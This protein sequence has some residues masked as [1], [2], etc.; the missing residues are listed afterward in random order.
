MMLALPQIIR[1]NSCR[2]PC[3]LY[4]VRTDILDLV[5]VHD[6]AGNICQALPISAAD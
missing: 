3:I 6:I 4:G 1:P 2:L 5:F